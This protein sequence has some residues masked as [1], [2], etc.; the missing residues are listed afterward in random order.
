MCTTPT[1]IYSILKAR[2]PGVQ[3]LPNIYTSPQKVCDNYQFSVADWQEVATPYM[4]R[5]FINDGSMAR[6]AQSD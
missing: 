3:T 2:V 6:K 5:T 1:T 4:W